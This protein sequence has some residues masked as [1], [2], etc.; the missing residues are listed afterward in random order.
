MPPKQQP[1]TCSAFQW[2]EANEADLAQAIKGLCLDRLVGAHDITFLVPGAAVQKEI[3]DG[4]NSGTDAAT[5]RANL[6]VKAHIVRAYLA[7]PE[8]FNRDLGSAAGVRLRAKDIKPSGVTLQDGAVLV[9]REANRRT[10]ATFAIWDVKS[11]AVST[12]GEHFEMKKQA[13]GG[14]HKQGGGGGMS[15]IGAAVLA[16]SEFRAAL[17][18]GCASAAFLG[19]AFALLTHLRVCGGDTF[20]RAQGVIDLD[21]VITF[22]LLL[23]PFKTVGEYLV[24]DDLLFGANGWCGASILP[25][26]DQWRALFE[27]GGTLATT[28]APRVQKLL[29]DF[30]VSVGTCDPRTA[31]KKVRDAYAELE[32]SNTVQGVGPVLGAVA[33]GR[34][35][36]DEC[37]FT[38]ALNLQEMYGAPGSAQALTAFDTVT[39]TFRAYPGNSADETILLTF[40]Q[41]DPASMGRMGGPTWTFIMSTDLLYV[42][43]TLA[44]LAS[45]AAGFSTTPNTTPGG[46]NRVY[47]RN[48][49]ALGLVSKHALASGSGAQALAELRLR[50]ALSG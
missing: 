27:G 17:A 47:E 46:D 12:D 36:Q 32:T 2:L 5:D 40:D 25:T 23:Q 20:L 15:R 7:S 19:R 28:D 18:C 31:V 30:R 14:H 38:A 50:T 3:I 10:G 24:S 8:D 42:P 35:V 4:Q 22:Y 39:Q 33:P 45:L 37:R 21:P 26:E 11:G 48:L 34:M 41:T 29:C 16:E 1:Q 49:V 6:L 13:P 9:R 43:E 44:S